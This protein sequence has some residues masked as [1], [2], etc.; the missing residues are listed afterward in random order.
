M[1]D[2]FSDESFQKSVKNDKNVKQLDKKL[3]IFQQKMGKHIA[4]SE[5]NKKGQNKWHKVNGM[6]SADETV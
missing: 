5:E 4:A 2:K 3:K 1:N 6:S